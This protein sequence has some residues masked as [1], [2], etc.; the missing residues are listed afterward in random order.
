MQNHIT[1][2]MD[3]PEEGFVVPVDIYFNLCNIASH[4]IEGQQE[5]A[6]EFLRYTINALQQACLSDSQYARTTFISQVFQGCLRSRVTCLNCTEASDTYD[7]FMDIQLDI[8]VHQFSRY[9]NIYLLYILACI[10]S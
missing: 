7:Q 5:D 2:V 6:H 8:R 3:K 4:F 1:K 10:R 9:N